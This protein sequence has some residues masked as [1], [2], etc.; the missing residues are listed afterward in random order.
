MPNAEANAAQSR[1]S[2][3]DSILR[4]VFT[5]HLY[6][7]LQPLKLATSNLVHN[8]GLRSRLSKILLG[9]NLT[10]VLARGAPQKF[11]DHLLI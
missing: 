9:P 2:R 11:W 5:V 3:D 10:G 4:V 1:K 8:S 7:F 6:L